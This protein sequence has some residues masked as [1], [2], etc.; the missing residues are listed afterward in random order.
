MLH[1]W[2]RWC[3]SSSSSGGSIISFAKLWT[4]YVYYIWGSSWYLL[5]SNLMSCCLIPR[6]KSSWWPHHHY[7]LGLVGGEYEDVLW[8][9][10]FAKYFLRNIH[11]H[12]G[13]FS[14]NHRW[15]WFQQLYHF[16]VPLL[17]AWKR[18][19]VAEV[20]SAVLNS[21][22]HEASFNLKFLS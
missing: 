1:W 19:G 20:N 5:P 4:I 16:L 14:Y 21:T 12:D 18:D 10:E 15:Q 8:G 22:L 17:Y 2:L 3:Q 11:L 13:P 6:W 9:V 7:L